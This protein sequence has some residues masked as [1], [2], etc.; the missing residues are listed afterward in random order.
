MVEEQHYVD[1]LGLFLQR[2]EGVSFEASHNLYKQVDESS[3]DMTSL[4]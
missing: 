4:I 2:K 1:I 3:Q